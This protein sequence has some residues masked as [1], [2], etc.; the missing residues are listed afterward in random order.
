MGVP[1]EGEGYGDIAAQSLDSIKDTSVVKVENIGNM[2]TV[3][4]FEKM[5]S[6]RDGPEWIGKAIKDMKMRIFD[7]VADSFEGDNYPKALECLVIYML[8]YSKNDLLITHALQR[9]SLEKEFPQAYDDV[10]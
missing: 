9:C 4:G 10:L 3:Q 2:T 7:L 5:M 8:Q 1:E 6:C